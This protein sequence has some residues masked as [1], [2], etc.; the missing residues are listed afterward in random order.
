VVLISITLAWKDLL[1]L[2]VCSQYRQI[3]L[4]TYPIPS[5]VTSDRPCQ[6]LLGFTDVLGG[7]DHTDWTDQFSLL[8][9]TVSQ[10]QSPLSL[11]LTFD[12]S[13]W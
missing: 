1:C 12:F 5:P 9:F 10:L 4:V 2:D 13:G 6:M 8:L 11:P 3:L 7:L